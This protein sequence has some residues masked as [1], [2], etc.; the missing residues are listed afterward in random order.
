[1]TQRPDALNDKLTTLPSDPGV[2]LMKD[3]A[4]DILYVGKASSLR[5]R[6]RSYFQSPRNLDSKTQRLVPRIGDLETIVTA[7]E[8]EA[9]ILEDTLIKK[10]K[11]PFNVRLRDD[12]RYPYLKLTAEPFPRLEITRELGTDAKRGARY[13]GPYTDAHSLREARKALQKIFRI[14]T[15][16]L[17][18]Q[19]EPVRERPCL[20]HYL[21][22][23][24]APCVQAIDRQRYN[25]KVDQAALFLEGR[26]DDLLQTLRGQMDGAAEQLD[27]ERAAAVRDRLH[28]LQRLVQ[29]QKVVDPKGHDRDAIALAQRNG[30]CSAQ[31]FFIRNGKLVGR[32]RF[33]M[34]A[35]DET[36]PG[37][38]LTAFVKQFYRRTATVP[39]EILVQHELDEPE[40]IE[41]WLSERRGRRVHLKRPQRGPKARLMATVARNAELTLSESQDHA[42]RR[43]TANRDGLAEL[44]ANLGLEAVPARIE[45]FDVSNIQGLDAVVSMVVFE[46]GSANKRHYRHFA[47]RETEGPDDYA[48]LAEAVRRR[49]Q[50]AVDG[51]EAFLPLPDL[52]LIDGGKGQLSTVRWAMKQLGF[53]NIPTLALAKEEEA[54]FQEGRSEPHDWRVDS[55]AAQLLQRVRDEAHRFALDRH[56]Q[57]RQRRTLQSSLDEI[58]G[59]GPARKQALLT[60]FGSMARLRQASLDELLAMPNLPTTIAQRVHRALQLERPR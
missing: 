22:L 47:I 8:R 26:H 51:D 28:A 9:L 53:A 44:Q 58:P 29:A 46:D 39:P 10:H 33:T 56:R 11:P 24:D 41:A 15:C 19:D 4:G 27:Y 42:E 50:R 17:D 52:I 31:I 54:V 23:C 36:D 43:Q 18:I 60:H 30:T 38:I 1:M 48:M 57:R 14:R 45:G 12:K 37:E 25:E 55:P 13:F 49:L 21:G 34:D 59:V 2:Y 3:D 7:T 16:S 5:S 32:E 20:D 40:T 6:V 35:D